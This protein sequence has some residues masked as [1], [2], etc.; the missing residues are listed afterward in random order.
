MKNKKERATITL[1]GGMIPCFILVL[2]SIGMML[3]QCL[4]N[5]AEVCK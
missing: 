3:Q 4:N 2:I 5:I 1:T